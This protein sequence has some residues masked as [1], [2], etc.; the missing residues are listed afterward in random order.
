MRLSRKLISTSLTN[1]GQIFS[2]KS[3]YI[4]LENGLV[5]LS[6]S[7]SNRKLF[8]KGNNHSWLNYR[9]KNEVILNRELHFLCSE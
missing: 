7:V 9:K 2:S 4:Y 5:N 1:K 6:G 8:D 3:F